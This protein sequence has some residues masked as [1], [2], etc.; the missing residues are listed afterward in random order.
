MQIKMAHL[1]GPLG[2][3]LAVVDGETWLYEKK[4]KRRPTANEVHFFFQNGME[5]RAVDPSKEAH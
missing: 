2:Q 5:V 3:A 4:D 1:C